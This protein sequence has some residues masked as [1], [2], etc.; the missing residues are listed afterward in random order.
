[1]NANIINTIKSRALKLNKTHRKTLIFIVLAAFLPSLIFTIVSAICKPDYEILSQL[2]SLI[3]YTLIFPIYGLG[4]PHAFLR[5][6]NGDSPKISMLL[7]YCNLRDYPA[8]LLT[9][10]VYTATLR[11]LT[12]PT[13]IAGMLQ[14]NR[15]AM[16]ALSQIGTLCTLVSLWLTLNLT[17]LPYLYSIGFSRNPFTLMR[18]SFQYMRGKVL[19]FL[20]FT[21]KLCWWRILIAVL[22]V[23][24]L[25]GTVLK[26]SLFT[27]P[28]TGGYGLA[29]TV[30]GVCGL[31]LLYLTLTYPLL[32]IAGFADSIIP[33]EKQLKK[34]QNQSGRQ[35]PAYHKET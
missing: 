6:W 31:L 2:I 5:V 7:R 3:F 11:L 13:M 1:M 26:A 28:V 4:L 29:F 34:T 32:A 22:L 30:Y 33:S 16:A 20:G 15:L 27:D 35:P 18:A 19:S 12:I 14:D 24:I 9:G 25:G 21:F 23:F 17:L 10:F 8:A